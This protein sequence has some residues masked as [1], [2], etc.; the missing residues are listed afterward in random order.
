M[1]LNVNLNGMSISVWIKLPED[2]SEWHQ[3]IEGHTTSGEIF[4]EGNTVQ[5]FNIILIL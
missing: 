5:R 3:I 1:L 2:I 4:L